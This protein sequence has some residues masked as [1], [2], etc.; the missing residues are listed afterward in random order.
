[1]SGHTEQTEPG[2]P[3]APSGRPAM[4][5]HACVTL[6][7]RA[8]AAKQAED[9]AGCWAANPNRWPAVAAM[10]A[11]MVVLQREDIIAD[12]YAAGFEASG[13]GWN[14][15]YPMTQEATE[16]LHEK[17]IAYAKAA[18]SD[19]AQRQDETVEAGPGMTPK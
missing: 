14:G 10:K 7:E 2:L 12:A 1:M 6:Y 16:W 13:E 19:G 4:S 18:L 9:P 5:L 8:Y 17:A 11:V 15:E 3:S